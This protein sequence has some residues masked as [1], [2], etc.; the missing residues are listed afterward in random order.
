MDVTR[1]DIDVDAL[2]GF[3]HG[4]ENKA[5]VDID[6][7]IPILQRSKRP[8]IL[9]GNGL[10]RENKE[11]KKAV[12]KLGIPVVSSMIAVDVQEG[13]KSFYGFV[14]AYGDRTAN[15]VIAKSDLIVTIGARLDVR[16]VGAKRENFAPEST[17]I[18]VDIDEG[19]LDY[20]V[21]DNEIDIIADTREFL[22][23]ILRK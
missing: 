18:R 12:N 2:E 10:D 23:E 9:I 6:E 5:K 15:F 4:E 17:L 13:L 21:H 3:I 11:W 19:E 16:Q 22:D 1:T 20:K 7:L 8:V 14:G